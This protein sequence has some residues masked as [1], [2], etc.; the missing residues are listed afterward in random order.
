MTKTTLRLMN[1]AA[2]LW[3]SCSG[4]GASAQTIDST[5]RAECV[6]GVIGCQQ[7]DFFLELVAAPSAQLT[8]FTLSLFTSGWGFD[9]YL[10]GEDA[11][12]FLMVENDPY[13]SSVWLTGYFQPFVAEVEPS[14]RLR[15]QM[16]EYGSD[17]TG[18]DISYSGE[19]CPG[20]RTA[21]MGQ[22][23][24]AAAPPVVIPTDPTVVPEPASMFLLGSGLAGLGAL[25]RRRG[26]GDSASS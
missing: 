3:F 4:V 13:N 12:D 16:A 20:C 10:E 6:G 26:R 15:V 22:V 25:R 17:I 14:L 2:V 21:V 5:V 24:T 11:V 23:N 9:R 7:I 1:A 8:S 18:L 19:E